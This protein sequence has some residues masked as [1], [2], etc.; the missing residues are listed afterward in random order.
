MCIPHTH[1]TYTSY[2]CLSIHLSMHM[3]CFHSWLS[4]IQLLWTWVYK[5][6]FKTQ[7][8]INTS[9][10]IPRS[11]NAKYYGN[12]I[13]NFLK[14]HCTIFYSGYII[15]HSHQECTRVPLFTHLHQHLFFIVPF[16][17]VILK[18]VKWYL[19]LVLTCIFL[20]ISDVEDLS[21]CLLAVC[22]EKSLFSSR[23]HFLIAF[24]FF[25]WVL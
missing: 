16:M 19:A 13:L 2:M 24:F 22:L 25:L 21:K 5:Y 20:I 23:A 11:R 4:W 14:T 15:L 18:G 7:L 1:H 12:S 3:E 8:L 9:E 6:L 10:Y 17:T